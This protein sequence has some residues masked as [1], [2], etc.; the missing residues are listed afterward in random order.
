MTRPA[1][2]FLPCL[3]THE[4]SKPE[5]YTT[6]SIAETADCRAVTLGRTGPAPNAGRRAEADGLACEAAGELVI[7]GESGVGRGRI[8]ASASVRLPRPTV[9][10]G[11]LDI[12]DGRPPEPPVHPPQPRPAEENREMSDDSFSGSEK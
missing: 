6:S 4:P 8:R 2:R 7:P 9:G 11:G 1:L 10:R 3:E 5:L 12:E